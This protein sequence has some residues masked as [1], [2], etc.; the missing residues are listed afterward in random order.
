MS[1]LMKIQIVGAELFHADRVTDRHDEANYGYSHSCERP[2]L[3]GRLSSIRT[4]S[5]IQTL[6]ELLM[7]VASHCFLRFTVC[8]LL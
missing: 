6:P 7:F 8:V 4:K 3:K 1:S 2:P 5:C